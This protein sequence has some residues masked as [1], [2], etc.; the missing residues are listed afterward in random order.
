VAFSAV[1]VRGSAISSA[2][3]TTI[4]LNPSA[5]LVVDKIIVVNCVTDNDSVAVSSGSSSRH[6]SVSDN[7][8]SSTNVWEKIAEYTQTSGTAANGVTISSWICKIT[9]QIAT[10]DAITLTIAEAVLEKAISAFETSILAGAVYSVSQVGVGQN[11]ITASVSSLNSREYLLVGHGGAEGTDS[12]KTPDANYTERFD[13]RTG[14]TGS[15]VTQH[16]VTR[17]A[18]LTGDSCTSSAWTNTNPMFLL[19]AIT[20]IPPNLSASVVDSLVS[21]DFVQLA[22]IVMT[23]EAPLELADHGFNSATG[24]VTFSRLSIGLDTNDYDGATYQ[25]EVI[26]TNTNV[27]TAYNIELIDENNTSVLTMNIPANTGVQ[28]IRNNFTPTTGKHV[29]RPKTPATASANNLT[30]FAARIVM[31]QTSASKTRLQIPMLQGNSTGGSNLDTTSAAIDTTTS[32]SYTQATPDLYSIW[33]YVASRYGDLVT[34]TPWE[35]E[36]VLSATAGN[37]AA[38]ALFDK[39][40]GNQVAGTEVTVTGTTITRVSVR[41]SASAANFTDLDSFE[42]RIKTNGGTAYIYRACLYV[43]LANLT[44]SEVFWRV[45]KYSPAGTGGLNIWQQRVLLDTGHSDPYTVYFETTGYCADNADRFFLVDDGNNDAGASGSDLTGGNVNYNSA[46]KARTRSG[47][48]TL[49]NPHRYY[50][51]RAASTANLAVASS[52]LV[53][54]IPQ[55]VEGPSASIFDSITTVESIAQ[56]LLMSAS[57]LDTISAAEVLSEILPEEVSQ[58]SLVAIAEFVAGFLQEDLSA[59]VVDAASIAEAIEVK[60][61]MLASVIDAVIVAEVIAASIKLSASIAD[62][63]AIAEF[64]VAVTSSV[65]DLQISLSDAI[66]TIEAVVGELSQA[67]T[68]ALVIDSVTVAEN[69]VGV[70]PISTSV[71]NA[72]TIVEA[73]VGALLISASV[74]DTLAVAEVILETLPVSA[75]VT[76]VLVVAE[77]IVVSLP[78]SASVADAVTIT[79]AILR[80]MLISGAVT[81]AVQLAE[82]IAVALSVSPVSLFDVVSVSEFITAMVSLVG[83]G[84][85]YYY[86][87]QL[88]QRANTLSMGV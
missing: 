62:T 30:I 33:N 20:E 51:R 60:L 19:I 32:V 81:D 6:T 13:L 15:R 80:T 72:V 10:T 18:I 17:I 61:P 44:A 58:F 26:V 40:T 65:V 83:G 50:V 78:I 53:L 37:I 41:F 85:P 28:R 3:G 14:S 74:V 73:V 16:V 5:N 86:Y 66:A 12:T 79:E 9:T 84:K 55:V 35:L 47:S 88:R 8:A 43:R 36:A 34:E 87:Q 21:S 52:W 22:H 82:A 11:A 77:A 49:T 4:P 70:L 42:L 1:V 7:A 69:I 59:S 75:S 2:S 24:A 67:P 71:E 25:L 45:G 76:D 63:V 57:V 38:C 68:E 48:L 54:R 46:T 64:I 29:Y 39:T 27:S 23:L 56:Q 31:Q